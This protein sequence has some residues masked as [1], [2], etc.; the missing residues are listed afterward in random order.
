MLFDF[1][2]RDANCV[3]Q[4]CLRLT[5]RLWIARVDESKRLATIHAFFNFIDS[6]SGCFH[7]TLL[8]R[9]SSNFCALCVTLRFSAFKTPSDA[10]TYA[11]PTARQPLQTTPSILT[12]TLSSE[13]CPA[14]LQDEDARR[15]LEIRRRSDR[16]LQRPANPPSKPL[17]TIDPDVHIASRATPLRPAV[18]SK[19]LQSHR[20]F[21]M[22]SSQH[23]MLHAR[24][25][26]AS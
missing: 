26:E 15:D 5:P 13:T 10:K 1:V 16:P 14:R 4:F 9:F 20:C 11:F 23:L 22:H 17:T 6:N 19:S 8:D 12:A 3:R 24:G 2:R 21:A 25:R 18:R 7:L